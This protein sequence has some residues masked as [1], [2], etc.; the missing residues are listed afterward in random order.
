[1]TKSMLRIFATIFGMMKQYIRK[2]IDKAGVSIFRHSRLP[3]GTDYRK[4]IRE[5]FG[6]NEINT[7]FDV[8]ANIG[9][10]CCHASELFNRA[11]IYSF[12]PITETYDV[13]INSTKNNL[14]INCFNIALGDEKGKEEVILQTNSTV[15]SLNPAVNI[16]KNKD[17]DSQIIS[18]ETLDSFCSENQIEKID[19][20]KIDTEGF[21]LYV[22][23][24]A[25]H[26]LEKRQVNFIF[27]E[28]TF[29]QDNVHNSSYQLISSYV[30][31][32][33]Y[34]LHGFY[35]QSIHKGSNRMNYCDAL[36]YLQPT[37]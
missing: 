25:R 30:E 19:L 31:Q 18:I 23:K 14:N 6:S 11:K 10:F 2:I 15:N 17:Q 35:N 24:G 21:D 9:Q 32:F 7:I 16:R 1:M 5:L 22:L 4:S 3:I 26:M 27:I 13:L 8:G 34:R 33:D 29:D 28:V 12:E 37:I 20:L 36:F